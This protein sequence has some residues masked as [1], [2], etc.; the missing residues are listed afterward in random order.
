M[1]LYAANLS[2]LALPVIKPLSKAQETKKRKR[3]EKEAA[4]AKAANDL[5]L[6]AKKDASD[7]KKDLAKQ[8]REAKKEKVEKVEAEKVVKPKKSNKA[9]KANKAEKV[10]VSEAEE[11]EDE[12]EADV[13]AEQVVDESVGESETVAE[14]P[15][16]KQK[17]EIK[18]VAKVA[19]LSEEVPPAW[20]NK[21]MQGFKTEEV[22]QGKVKKPR[23][24]II[25]ESKVAAG[26]A[27][28]DGLTRNRVTAEVNDH[29]SRMYQQSKLYINSSVWKQKVGII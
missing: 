14:V 13:E 26:E 3:E 18:T 12:D 19:T 4:T 25:A 15:Q 9:N 17:K 27:W 6:Q 2:E 1:T 8:K 7:A 24:V 20:F 10:D 16:K 28:N 11:P 23:K 21:I 5:A 29:M 22:K